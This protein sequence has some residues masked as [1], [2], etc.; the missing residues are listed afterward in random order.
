[1]K[2]TKNATYTGRESRYVSPLLE[3]LSVDSS[4]VLCQSGGNDDFIDN[5]T[6][7]DWFTE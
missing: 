7:V 6:P 2:E 3:L 4:G 5:T 1:M